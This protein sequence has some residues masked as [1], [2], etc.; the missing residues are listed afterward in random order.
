MAALWMRKH[1][2]HLSD[3]RVGAMWQESP[4]DQYFTG[5]ATSQWG[6]PCAESD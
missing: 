4:Y 5:E 6:P 1:R 3:E 2:Y